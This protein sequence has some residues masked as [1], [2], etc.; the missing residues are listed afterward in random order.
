MNLRLVWTFG[1]AGY[2]VALMQGERMFALESTRA[3][4]HP[5]ST[6]PMPTESVGPESHRVDDEV[7][8]SWA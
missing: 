5:W 3:S 8:Q 7:R 6:E 4:S 2:S 1:S